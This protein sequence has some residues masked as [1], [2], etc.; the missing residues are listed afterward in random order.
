MTTTPL[1]VSIK[2]GCFALVHLLLCNAYRADLE[3]RSALDAALRMR[4]W[5]MV[6]LLLDWG[7]EASSACLHWILDS[8]D[9]EVM[10]LFWRNG[11]DLTA[12]DEMARALAH[13]TRNRPLYG[14]AKNRRLSDARIQRALDVALGA[15]VKEQ[16]QK[17]TSLCLWAGANPRRRVAE[18]GLAPC[19][20]PDGFTAFEQAVASDATSFLARLGF[21]PSRDQVEPLYACVH[22]LDALRALVELCPPDN[23]SEVTQRFVSRLAWSVDISCRLSL[24]GFSYRGASLWTVQEVFGLGGHLGP[25]DRSLKK[26]L[27][28]LLLSLDEYNAKRLFRLLRSPDNMEPRAFLDLIAHDKLAARYMSWSAH[29]GVDRELIR[30]LAELPTAPASVRKSARSRAEPPRHKAVETWLEDA[31]VRRRFSREEI[32]ELVWSEPLSTLSHR[33]GISDQGLRKHCKVLGVPTPPRGYWQRVKNGH[34]T[35]R[36][37]LPP[38][39]K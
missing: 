22:D 38:L 26:D 9:R 18:P 4:R 13:S 16:N 11:V 30:L 20:D 39:G 27:R 28:R 19:D 10:E 24:P 1:S 31:G 12:D 15:A 25:L 6:V 32:Y 34:R 14:F 37:P 23:W 21:D 29:A 35:R 7:I 2:T 5:D 8:Y 3:P 33:F 36:L 17:A